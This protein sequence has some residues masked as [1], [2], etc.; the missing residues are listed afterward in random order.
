MSLKAGAEGFSTAHA[1]IVRV[2]K[3]QE[4]MLLCGDFVK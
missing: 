4:A 1:G 2:E 3:L